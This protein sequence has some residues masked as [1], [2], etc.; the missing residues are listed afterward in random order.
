MQVF[1]WKTKIVLPQWY[2]VLLYTNFTFHQVQTLIISSTEHSVS[3]ILNVSPD[4][5]KTQK[6]IKRKLIFPIKQF[7]P[8]I[9]YLDNC[10]YYIYNVHASSSLFLVLLNFPLIT[11]KQLKESLYTCFVLS[12]FQ[13]I[14]VQVS[15]IPT[16]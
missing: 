8:G 1:S 5:R 6:T 15:S 7:L 11:L 9:A 3:K 16:D 13:K 2:I 4:N 10:V 14:N 12:M